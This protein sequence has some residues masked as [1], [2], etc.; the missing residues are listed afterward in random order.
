MAIF[1]WID[2]NGIPGPDEDEMPG[3]GYNETPDETI[4]PDGYDAFHGSE[5]NDD[6]EMPGPGYW[7]KGDY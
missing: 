5:V 2:D 1:D 7:E 6:E 4:D 3:P